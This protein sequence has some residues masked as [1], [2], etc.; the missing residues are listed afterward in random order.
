MEKIGRALILEGDTKIATQLKALLSDQFGQV[1]F[2]P[3]TAEALKLLREKEIQMAFVGD[4]SE[5]V[6]CFDLLKDLVRA[7]PMTYV[8]LITDEPEEV[9]HE[10]A[11]GY[12]ILGHIPRAFAS[13]HIQTLVNKYKQITKGL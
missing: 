11:E 1:I 10:K 6:S 5:G 9:I 12:G 2:A 13:S 3:D 4:P 7:S 8:V